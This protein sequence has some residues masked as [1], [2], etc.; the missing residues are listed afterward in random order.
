MQFPRARVGAVE[1]N[2]AALEF[3]GVAQVLPAALLVEARQ[4]SDQVQALVAHGGCCGPG[5][6]EQVPRE[7]SVAILILHVQGAEVGGEVGP[8][9]EVV[10]DDAAP[11]NDGTCD[12]VVRAYDVPLGDGAIGVGA[13]LHALSVCLFRNAPLRREPRPPP[14]PFRDAPPPAKRAKARLLPRPCLALPPKAS[15]FR[16]QAFA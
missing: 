1:A 9:V 5:V 7:A 4:I 11:C 6:V 14:P 16:R 8:V 10:L 3:V 2:R 12:L 13:F 15:G